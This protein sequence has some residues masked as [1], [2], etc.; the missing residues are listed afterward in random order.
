MRQVEANML[1]GKVVAVTCA[2]R[3]VGEAI[4]KLMAEHGAC[5]VVNDVPGSAVHE[6]VKDI[7]AAGG[8]AV[9]CSADVA[10]VEGADELARATMEAFIEA[11]RRAKRALLEA[12]CSPER[13]LTR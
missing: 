3:G 5:V 4:C 12:L 6:V 9:G 1:R 8:M 11:K 10:T 2:S 7:E 13:A